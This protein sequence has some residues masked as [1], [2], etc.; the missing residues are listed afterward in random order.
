MKTGTQENTIEFK[1]GNFRLGGK[2]VFLYSGELHYFR[3]P[4]AQWKDRLRKLKAAGFNTVSS[5]IPWI[6]HEP[7]E[8]R[9]DLTGRTHPERDVLGF[10][11]LAAKEGLLA[12]VR[13]G[14]VS[15]AELKNEGLPVWLTQKFPD[16]FVTGHRDVGNLPHV[17]MVSY[18]HPGF[19]EKVGNWYDGLLPEIVKR[20][21]TRGGNVTGVQLCNEVAMVHW[22]QKGADY[23]P[24]VNDMYRSFLQEKYGTV[25]KLNEA[26]GSSH[27]SFEDVEQPAPSEKVEL[28]R[29]AVFHDWALF[30]RRYY[31]AYFLSL[32]SRA[33]AHG[34]EVPLFCNIPQFYDYDIR[35]RGVYSPMTTSMF[36]DFPLLTPNLIF[37]GAYQMRHLDFENFHDVALTTEVTRLLNSA[38]P[39]RTAVGAGRSRAVPDFSKPLHSLPTPPQHEVSYDSDVPVV[40]AE[41]QTGIMR[42]RPR[43]YP[44]QVLLHLKSAVSQG[45]GGVNA[46]MFAGGV[47]APGYGM[48]GTYHDWQA[49]V[50]AR[51]QEKPHLQPLKDFGRFLSWA[52][53]YL[54]QTQKAVDT[55]LGFYLP[56]YATEYFTGT[57]VEKLEGQRTNLWYDGMARLVQ[58]A[59]Y[60]YNFADLQRTPLDVLKKFPSLWVYSLDFM[61]R[62]TQAKLA[63]YVKEGGKLVLYPRLPSLDLR[64]EEET[65]LGQ[66]LGLSRAEELSGNLYSQDGKD[67]WVQGPIQAFRSDNG[68]HPFVSLSKGAAA[69]LK[70]SVGRGEVLAVGFGLPHIFD[71]YRDWVRDWGASLGLAPRVVC[72][73]WDVQATLRES[74]DF[75]FLFVFNYHFIA[76]DAA[77]SLT[78]PGSGEK[79]RFPEKGRLRLEP[80][81]GIALPLNIPLGPD[82]RLVYA[83]AEPR[84][85]RVAAKRVDLDLAAEP[86]QSVEVCLSAGQKP[87]SARAGAQRAAVVWRKGRALVSFK[88]AAPLT[89]LS[90]AW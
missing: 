88:A 5:Y 31:A 21:V 27:A 86:G 62:D 2:P 67:Y 69:A 37:G 64:G 29:L 33:K 16:L 47:N 71:H 44:P 46:Y 85:L 57:W 75:G 10:F 20:Q 13:V 7:E 34:V 38:R 22:L 58:L 54:A 77:L 66:E 76:K 78:L 55:A 26:H 45:L 89:K 80:L 12:M 83:T 70:K 53:P 1:G 63:A 51:G 8:G 17:T 60:N 25:E 4:K 39:A 79:I 18:L 81:S 50:D 87:R 15:N 68:H 43:I 82:K 24:H 40:C 35:G 84:G 59:G 11:D 65:L 49:P 6:W 36:R 52:G 14:P 19:Q 9:V 3:V 41:L 56:Y 74:E 42:D 61:D 73:P 72:D 32:S 48:F 23:K 30:Y 90:A 28:P